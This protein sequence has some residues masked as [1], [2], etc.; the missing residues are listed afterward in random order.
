MIYKFWTALL[1][2]GLLVPSAFAGEQAGSQWNSSPEGFFF[3]GGSSYL[4][5]DIRDITPERMGALKLKEERGVE[6]VALDQ[7]APAGKAGLKEHDVILEYNGAK[8]ESQEQL[9]RLIRETPPGRTVA[10][11]ISRD[12]NPTTLN[13]QLGDRS[14]LM[15]EGWQK[16]NRDRIMVMPPMPDWPEIDLSNVDIHTLNNSYSLGMQLETLNEQLGQFFGVK[17]GGG[18]LVKSVGKGSAAEKAGIKAGDVVVRIDNDKVTDRADLRRV[19]RSHQKGGKITLGIVREKH[20]QNIPL[21]LPERKSNDSSGMRINLPGMDS[22]RDQLAELKYDQSLLT[23]EQLKPE[24]EKAMRQYRSQIEGMRKLYDPAKIRDLVNG[25]MKEME[26]IRPE[27]DK[28]MQ[29]YKLQM[30]D[31]RKT[32]DPKKMEEQM[33]ELKKLLSRQMV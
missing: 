3:S 24:I 22:L 5:I 18:L 21:D 8:V 4:G 33:K 32:Y 17:G 16:A 11:G 13:V 9:R 25:Q 1:L 23:Q 10:L 7:D 26:K 31:F 27:I 12:G 6:V 29:Q 15:A 20:E 28:A 14:K 2:L 19:M 30:E